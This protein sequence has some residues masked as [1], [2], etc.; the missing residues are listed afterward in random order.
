SSKCLT[1]AS[2][3]AL[4]TFCQNVGIDPIDFDTTVQ[5]L[6]TDDQDK[7][8]Y[9]LAK[10]EIEHTLNDS[11]GNLA[12][13]SDCARTLLPLVSQCGLYSD[14]DVKLNFSKAPSVV[15]VYSPVVLTSTYYHNFIGN[16]G[17]P[18]ANN[19]FL[20]FTY[21]SDD[22]SQL[23]PQ[24][25][26]DLRKMQSHILSHYNN[27][28]P[29]S[30]FDVKPDFDCEEDPLSLE[31]LSEHLLHKYFEMNPK[32]TIFDIRKFI[33]TLT[34]DFVTTH[35]K[36]LPPNFNTLSL[37]VIKWQMYLASVMRTGPGAC[38]ALF[39]EF[40]DVKFKAMNVEVARPM[41]FSFDSKKCYHSTQT[42]ISPQGKWRDYCAKCEKY[43]YKCNNLHHYVES[44]QTDVQGYKRMMAENNPLEVDI[45]KFCDIS[46]TKIGAD[47]QQKRSQKI[48]KAANTIVSAYREYKQKKKMRLEAVE[49]ITEEVSKLSL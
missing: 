47:N 41:Y 28:T 5:A 32:A 4:N 36:A 43:G 1:Q 20:G 39:S 25:I 8:I 13:A 27:I 16:A 9:A 6:L 46:W 48:T 2:I 45:G 42:L 37:D 30:F 29:D 40:L 18:V 24:A 33:E 34:I 38:C 10:S 11:G 3:E 15:K 26:K 22:L 23:N 31:T 7:Q 14:F 49:A 19:D 17:Y 21:D 35:C 12:A 44:K